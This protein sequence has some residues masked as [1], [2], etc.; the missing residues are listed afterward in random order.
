[1]P[2]ENARK[3]LPDTSIEPC[4]WL[5][6]LPVAALSLVLQQLDNMLYSSLGSTAVTC[7]GLSYALPAAL[8]QLEVCCKQHDEH[9]TLESLALWLRQHSTRLTNLQRCSIL[10][11]WCGFGLDN[12][13]ILRNRP[14][15][16]LHTLHLQE[17][18]MQLPRARGFAGVL[19]DCTGLTT[20]HLED[21]RVNMTPAARA[22]IA[23][24]PALQSLEVLW[25]CSPELLAEGRCVAAHFLQLQH[26]QQL[27]QLRL[28]FGR[29]PEQLEHLQQL[30][31]LTNLQRLELLDMLPDAVPGGLPSQLVKLTGLFVHCHS[32]SG[33]LGDAATYFQHLSCLTALQELLVVGCGVRAVDLPGLWHLSQLTDLELTSSCQDLT[34]DSTQHWT[35]LAALRALAV[36]GCA[37]QPQALTAATQ[38]RE[39]YS[40][41]P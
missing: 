40:V 24:L 8:S 16:G 37:V 26:P 5:L 31:T 6:Q 3:T 41:P 2:R 25:V 28:R 19:G 4:N 1:M 13:P 34:A 38:L 35:R 32:S 36:S 23:A 14:C 39:L 18:R 9:A 12:P 17:L 29:D 27:T 11:N 21:C 15:P 10:S 30:P 33:G 7:S 20:L 22:A